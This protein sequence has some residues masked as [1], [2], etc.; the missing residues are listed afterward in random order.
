MKVAITGSNGF[1]GKYLVEAFL[2]SGYEVKAFV[3][4]SAK[5]SHIE[6]HKN[7]KLV[8]IDYNQLPQ[9]LERI[10]NET[11]QLDYLIHNA[12][13]TTSVYPKDYEEI[14][15]QLTRRLVEGIEE[16][17]FISKKLIYISSYTAHGPAG[18]GHP[19]SAYGASKLAAES[20]ILKSK[21]PSLIFRPTGIYGAGDVAFLP[22]FK[23]AKRGI[24]PINR[25]DQKITMIHAADMAA[26]VPHYIDNGTGIFH[27]ND[28][29]IYSN[30]DM[31][32]ALEEAFKK[33]I[34]KIRIP[35]GISRFGLSLSDTWH[36]ITG[37]PTDLTREK[38]NEIA[39]DW[40]LHTFDG[41]RHSEAPVAFDLKKGFEN[42]YR[43]YIDNKLI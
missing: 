23:A 15:V 24:Y 12:G 35:T 30:D 10:K 17:N 29:N 38:F 2:Q 42:A 19:V 3:R 25:S 16:T 11:G 40:D 5:T 22:L 41:L 26:A 4:K 9:E 13:K 32:D 1:L 7:L 36:K 43:Y 21:Y 39:H 28:G 34:R 33:K 37:G 6:H 27:V 18:V 14:N 31:I 20:F 8:T